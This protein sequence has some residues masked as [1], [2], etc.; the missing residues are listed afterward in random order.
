MVHILMFLSL[1]VISPNKTSDYKIFVSKN[2]YEAD[3]WVW[4]TENRYQAA[5]REDIWYITNN[6]YN[7][8]FSITFVNSKYNSNLV[9]YYTDN[10]YLAGWKK[11]HPLKNILNIR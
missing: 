2:R 11:Q 5:N 6:R 8:N 1:V 3:L 10:R 9:I 4:K 7:S